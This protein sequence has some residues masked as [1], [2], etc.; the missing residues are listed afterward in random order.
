[1]RQS[2]VA[3]AI[4]VIWV[5]AAMPLGAQDVQLFDQLNLKIEAS[6]VNFEYRRILGDTWRMRAGLGWLAVEIQDVKGGQWIGRLSMEHQTFTFIGFGLGINYSTIEVDGRGEE[7]RG[8]VDMDID[9][10]S[11]YVRIHL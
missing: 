11:V 2:A 8:V 6:F 1:M 7:F 5:G 9:D 10:V 4:L 3:V